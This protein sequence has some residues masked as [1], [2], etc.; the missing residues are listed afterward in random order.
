MDVIPNIILTL[1]Y[2]PLDPNIS[3]QINTARN[4]TSPKTIHHITQPTPLSLFLCL[5]PKVE[6]EDSHVSLPDR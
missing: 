5:D 4:D 6:D 3:N 2:Q 1:S